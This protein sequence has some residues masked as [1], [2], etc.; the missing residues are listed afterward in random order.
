MERIRWPWQGAILFG[1]TKDFF[2]NAWDKFPIQIGAN[3]FENFVHLVQLFLA[4][5]KGKVLRVR[6]PQQ[7]A[8]FVQTIT[9]RQKVFSIF[10]TVAFKG[11]LNG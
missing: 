10:W 2:S 7:L 1:C 11:G 8:K 9:V 5:E 3:Q 4:F 6:Q